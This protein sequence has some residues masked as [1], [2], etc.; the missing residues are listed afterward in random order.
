VLKETGFVGR[1]ER[2]EKLYLVFLGD[3]VDRPR[4]SGDGGVF[5]VLE[6]A[7]ALKNQF[8]DN[9]VIIPGNHDV[10]KEGKM[11]P[12]EFIQEARLKYGSEMGSIIAEKYRVFFE[13]MPIAV[14]MGNGV[15]A[16]HGGAASTVKNINDVITPTE[17][18]KFQMYWNDPRDVSGY[19]LN[20]DRW[21]TDSSHLKAFTFGENELDVFLGAVGSRVMVRAHEQKIQH[22]F[23]GKCLTLNSTDYEDAQ[24]AYA[25]VDLSREIHNTNQIEIHYF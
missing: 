25:V 10:A 4:N 5:K 11:S 2:G 16:S 23:N 7:L 24:K 15:F 18:T 21:F 14:K 1:V 9:V 6:T 22:D 12:Q 20:K 8:W 19:E 3:F 17:E 13:K